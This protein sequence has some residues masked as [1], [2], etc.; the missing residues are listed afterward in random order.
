[1]DVF[2]ANSPG[3]GAPLIPDVSSVFAGTGPGNGNEAFGAN[4]GAGSPQISG[5]MGSQL[6]FWLYNNTGTNANLAARNVQFLNAAAP[7]FAAYWQLNPTGELVYAVPVPEP[8]TWAM[9]AAGLLA[10]G[11]IARRRVTA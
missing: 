11:A 1:M 8:G 3:Q 10:V 6:G 9:L 5:A 2:L 4:L 7:A